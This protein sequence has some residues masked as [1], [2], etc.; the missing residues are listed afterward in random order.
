MPEINGERVLS[1]LRALKALA[2]YES[3][4]H[5]PTLSPQHVAS[6]KWLV[7]ELGAIGH[8]TKL[9]GIGN[10][11]GLSKATGPKLIGGSHLESQNHAGWLDG[12]LGVVYALEAA[13]A[14][15]ADPAFA[16]CGVDV[17]ACCD[18]EGHFGSFLGSRS[19]V[20]EVDEAAIDAAVDRTNGTPFRKALA[21]AGLAGVPRYVLDAKRYVGFLEAHIEQGDWLEANDLK[22]GVVTRIVG[23]RQYLIATKGV[24]NHAGTTRMAIRKDAGVAAARIAVAISDRFPAQAGDRT[25]WTMGRMTYDPGA[26]SI[27]PGDAELVLQMRDP[28]NEVLDRLEAE[29]KKI[30]AEADKSGPCRVSFRQT[31]RTEPALMAAN[32]MEAVRGAAE[33]A[34]PGKHVDMP[35]GAGHDAM[36]FA[37]H[38]PSGMLFVPSIGGISHHW[39]ENTA[40]ADIVTGARVYVDAVARLLRGGR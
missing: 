29:A 14:I 39:T 24:Q 22:I 9:D 40:D 35:S 23:I 25:V 17:I 20:G 38:M 16:D 12:P 7:A 33:A 18:E 19:S 11:F 13:R 8:E 27:I 10:V 3:G 2:P 1:D 31:R 26:P 34:V 21:D 5:R 28:E 4:V 36:V 32:F 15:A 6:L 37:G 30:V